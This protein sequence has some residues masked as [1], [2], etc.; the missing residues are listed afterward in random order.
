MSIWREINRVHW[1]LNNFQGFLSGTPHPWIN[2]PPP[3]PKLNMKHS[4]WTYIFLDIQ[5]KLFNFQKLSIHQNGQNEFEWF[6]SNDHV[7]AHIP[8]YISINGY[9]II[10]LCFNLFS[11]PMNY[12][13]KSIIYTYTV[14]LRN[15]HPTGRIALMIY[16]L[17]LFP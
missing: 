12:V 1:D 8:V 14:T 16:I 10:I 15:H 3:S 5:P 17:H 2:T 13:Y 11:F 4:T 6:H 9:V 7:R